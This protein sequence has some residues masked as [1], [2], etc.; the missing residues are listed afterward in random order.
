MLK[1]LTPH[2]WADITSEA[3]NANKPAHVAVAYFGRD[4][5]GLLPLKAGS[6][7][8]VDASINTVKSGVTS[9]N[10]LEKLRS[11]GVEIYSAQNLHSKIFAFDK[12]GFVGSSNASKHSASI[13]I[14]TVL[15]TDSKQIIKSIR[16]FVDILAITKLSKSD[17]SDLESFYVAPK[18]KQ[19]ILP[20][21]SR[22]STLIMELTFEQGGGRAKQV[23]PP[24]AVWEEYFQIDLAKYQ[25]VNIFLTDENSNIKYKRPVIKHD[26]NYTIEIAGAELPRPAI[27]QVRKIASKQFRYSVHRPQDKTFSGLRK[28]LDEID[29]P[30]RTSGRKWLLI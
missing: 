23:Q 2:V 10:S 27:L 19:I 8:V 26:H 9:P 6:R 15:R 24:K 17:L 5:H 20:K 21:Q 14:E 7:L 3:K 30:M 1:L 4:G 13:L 29:N 16:D 12:V 22:L 25:S 11:F 28:L 18:K